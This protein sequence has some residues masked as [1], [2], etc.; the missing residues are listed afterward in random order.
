LQRRRNRERGASYDAQKTEHGDGGFA[1]F[2][3]GGRG[4]A[5][6]LRTAEAG[7]APA[8]QEQFGAGKKDMFV[9]FF[10]TLQ[11]KAS[12]RGDAVKSK[13]KR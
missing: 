13:E 1:G 2:V 9:N 3:S 4:A 7:D 12:L 8:A 5:S 11:I 6:T 10:L